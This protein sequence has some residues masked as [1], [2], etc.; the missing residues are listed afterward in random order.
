MTLLKLVFGTG[1]LLMVTM[2]RG[3]APPSIST[4]P[5]SVRVELV[6]GSRLFGATPI[7]AVRLNSSVGKLELPLSKVKTI[8]FRNEQQN[9]TVTLNNGDTLSGKLD[10]TSLQ[11]RTLLGEVKVDLHNCSTLTVLGTSPSRDHLVLWNT[12]GSKAEIYQSRVGPP[13]KY[14]G[15]GGRFEKGRFG[16]IL[17]VT[18]VEQGM[19][20]FP[21]KVISPSAG[22][23]EVWVKLTGFPKELAWGENPAL[24][25]TRVPGRNFGIHLNGNDGT[26]NGGLCGWAGSCGT[27]GTDV[28]GTWTYER[29][30]GTGKTEQWHHY[31]LVWDKNGIAGIGDGQKKL[32]IFLDGKLN[33]TSWRR[34]TGTDFSPLAEDDELVL[35]TQQHL[36]EGT[37]SFGD[38]RV[39]N[40]AKTDFSDRFEGKMP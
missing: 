18:Q 5:I 36:A 8:E 40:C 31:A 24:V 1:V 3:E 13:G 27:V 32:A 25:T 9:V 35:M 33:S 37:V 39:W 2:V 19:V 10:V 28:F 6:D 7:L 12:L 34:D 30:L 29:V 26:G 16:G 38:I 23:I 4:R 17:V 21:A 11:L 14:Q 20:S 22:C 15:E